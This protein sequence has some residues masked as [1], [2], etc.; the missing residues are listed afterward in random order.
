MEN[1]PDFWVR[2]LFN[3]VSQSKI[4][5]ML[6]FG[7]RRYPHKS[8]LDQKQDDQYSRSE[9]VIPPLKLLPYLQFAILMVTGF[10]VATVGAR[11]L[12]ESTIAPIDPFSAYADIFPGQYMRDVQARGFLCNN[13]SDFYPVH[14]EFCYFTP[15][16]GRVYGV[17]VIASENIIRQTTFTM[18]D[19]SLKLGD[20][21]LLTESRDLHS[22]LQEVIFFSNK[23]FSISLTDTAA[24]RYL[25]RP[26]WSISFIKLDPLQ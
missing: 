12:A 2:R 10:A 1:T 22:Y 5:D 25:F 21:V 9:N 8:S 23:G 17:Y 15:L 26:V 3:R 7:K 16:S 19:D 6:V 24:H 20:L 4:P 14:V 13:H 11:V 18:R